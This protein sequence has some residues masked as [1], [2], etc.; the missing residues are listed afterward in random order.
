MD[1]KDKE[2]QALRRRLEVVTEENDALLGEIYALKDCLMCKHRE[3]RA[4]MCDLAINWSCRDK[5]FEWRGVH[6][7]LDWQEEE[8][9]RRQAEARMNAI[10]E[11]GEQVFERRFNDDTDGEI[12]SVH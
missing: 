11:K 3:D 10:S 4:T 1:E 7:A 9:N 5:Q 2:I 12:P 6:A 8:E